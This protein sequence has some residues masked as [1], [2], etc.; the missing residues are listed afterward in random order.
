MQAKYIITL[1]GP[2]LIPFWTNPSSIIVNKKILG[3]GVLRVVKNPRDPFGFD[4]VCNRSANS[5]IELI[6]HRNNLSDAK[7]LKAMLIGTR[8]YLL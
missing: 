8:D 2:I 6:A 5:K 1:S 7:K 3:E 4:V